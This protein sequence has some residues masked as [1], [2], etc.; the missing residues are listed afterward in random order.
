MTLEEQLS[1]YLVTIADNVPKVYEAGVVSAAE[2]CAMEHYSTIAYADADGVT[3][4]FPF[5]PDVVCI[6]CFDPRFVDKAGT[7]GYIYEPWGIGQYIGF[8]ARTAGLAVL[9]ISTIGTYLTISE[10][11]YTFK[12]DA[13][14]PWRTE[15]AYSVVACRFP[16]RDD[17][18]RVR[19][20][21]TTVAANSKV[22]LRKE[23]VEAAFTDDEW[24]ALLAEYP[25]VTV[26]LA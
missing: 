6:I 17:N 3:I 16:N 7:F 15:F 11:K 14:Y 25:S 13:S 19:E 23:I 5:T 20:F 18:A 1:A 2:E 22:T 12:A 4:E 24:N 26:A 9:S 8:R 10:N 21:F